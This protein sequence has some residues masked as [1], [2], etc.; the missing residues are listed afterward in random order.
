[1]KKLFI[2]VIIFLVIPAVIFVNLKNKYNEI[3]R[4]TRKEL[5]EI[6]DTIY[7]VVGS[8]YDPSQKLP[9][10][11]DN[12][13]DLVKKMETRAVLGIHVFNLE[14]R[15]KL[16]RRFMDNAVDFRQDVLHTSEKY[17]TNEQKIDLMRK[18][19]LTS[20]FLFFQSPAINDKK[21]EKDDIFAIWLR[22][23]KE[24][25]VSDSDI[26]QVEIKKESA[27]EN[28]DEW[29]S[30]DIADGQ[31]V[32]PVISERK[33]LAQITRTA[34]GIGQLKNY[35]GKEF[36]IR[37][38]NGNVEEGTLLAVEA[39]SIKLNVSL[40]GGRASILIPIAQIKEAEMLIVNKTLAIDVTKTTEKSNPWDEYKEMTVKRLEAIT[41][42]MKQYNRD[43]VFNEGYVLITTD[44][45]MYWISDNTGRLVAHSKL[46]KENF[47]PL[48]TGVKPGTVRSIGLTGVSTITV[49][50]YDWVSIPMKKPPKA[51]DIKNIKYK[52]NPYH[53]QTSE[54]KPFE[55][56][57]K[58]RLVKEIPGVKDKIEIV[59]KDLVLNE[60][61]TRTIVKAD[62]LSQLADMMEDG[63]YGEG[64]KPW[65]YNMVRAMSR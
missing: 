32:S 39:P 27:S 47:T 26:P 30:L 19:I 8:K 45:K 38:N 25:E 24:L 57:F 61:N 59:E 34:V 62:F 21:D 7:R 6:E 2:L 22:D 64:D 49:S 43:K 48:A 35:I 9:H 56:R 17:L 3:S 15:K 42:T 40:G 44:Y 11:L 46:S 51:A 50:N 4:Q 13:R 14:D 18:F 60:K 23:M 53:S 10:I 28:L 12:L 1:M 41:D 55:L 20:N 52:H 58:I 63:R 65:E 54:F 37:L 5:A 36:E 33:Y 16:Y 31:A 29:A